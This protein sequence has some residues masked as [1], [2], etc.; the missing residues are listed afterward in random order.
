VMP[1]GTAPEPPR[2]RD[3]TG[4]SPMPPDSGPSPGRP[5][6]GYTRPL[7]RRLAVQP[8]RP[9]DFARSAPITPEPPDDDDDG[10]AGRSGNGEAAVAVSL[11]AE[12]VE[13]RR[14][15][16]EVSHARDELQE[17][18]LS[19]E[20]ELRL[21]RDRAPAMVSAATTAAASSSSSGSSSSDAGATTPRMSPLRLPHT[22]AAAAA[23]AEASRQAAERHIEELQHLLYLFASPLTLPRLDTAAEVEALHEA[24]NSCFD[25]EVQVASVTSVS[26]AVIER[27]LWIHISAHSG[28]GGNSLILEED[29]NSLGEHARPL[30]LAGLEELLR[31]GGGVHCAFLFLAACESEKIARVFHAAGVQNVVYC[32][33]EVHDSRA[34]LFATSLYGALSKGLSVEQAFAKARCAAKLSG[35]EA[36]YGLL[37]THHLQLRPPPRGSPSQVWLPHGPHRS[38]LKRKVEDFVGRMDTIRFV[39][40]YLGISKRRFV[41]LHCTTPL[42]RS[43][44]LKEVAH[45]VTAPGRKFSGQSRCAFFPSEAPGGLLIVDDIDTLTDME[46]EKVRQHLEV[47]GSQL[48]A[49]SRFDDS[50]QP[51]HDHGKPMLV[52]LPPLRNEEAAELFLRRCRRPLMLQDMVSPKELGGRDPKKVLDR[53]D[54][55]HFLKQP[56]KAFSG[57]PG[58]I[59]RAVDDWASRGSPTL[60][61]QVAKLAASACLPMITGGL[62]SPLCLPDLTSKDGRGG[63]GARPRSSSRRWR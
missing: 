53:S 2:G 19:A 38:F 40:F 52:E 12:V 32:P 29:K 63:A 7:Y 8:S 13:L 35:D 16:R 6:R 50:G 22:A 24:G 47:E 20:A 11:A 37:S 10:G 60:Y 59:R 1:P 33:T 4:I 54:A 43:A 39:L 26:Q 14:Q 25:I 27:D 45:L 15:L 17:A 48:L 55:L 44:T 62:P 61:G 57:A 31:T 30:A 41:L 5:R 28:D 51:F 49:G 46:R 18:H 58:R 42:G 3:D 9:A 23:A 21:S 56:I 34:R 36:Q